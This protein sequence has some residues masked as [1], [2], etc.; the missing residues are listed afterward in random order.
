MKLSAKNG[1]DEIYAAVT[2]PKCEA[3]EN[4]HSSVWEDD[5][6]FDMYFATF[7]EHEMDFVYARIEQRARRKTWLG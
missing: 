7:F 4:L 5:V 2:R 1:S 6:Q 3:F